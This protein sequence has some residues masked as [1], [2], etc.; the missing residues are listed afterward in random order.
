MDYHSTYH[1]GTSLSEHALLFCHG[2][3]ITASGKCHSS[4]TLDT[5]ASLYQSN[6]FFCRESDVKFSGSMAQWATVIYASKSTIKFQQTAELQ[7]N[8]GKVQ[9]VP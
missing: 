9:V 8:K 6:I 7:E 5:Q 2:T 3:H 4:T 1:Q